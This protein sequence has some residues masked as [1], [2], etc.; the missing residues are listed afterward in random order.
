MRNDEL[1]NI[2]G[3]G[4]GLSASYWNSISRAINT[5]YNLGKSIG[6]TARRIFGHC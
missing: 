4:F 3:G 6:A 2:V 5:F 1:L